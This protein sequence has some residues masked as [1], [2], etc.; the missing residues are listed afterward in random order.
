MPTLLPFNFH[1]YDG[2]APAPTALAVN[3]T[4]VPEQISVDEAPMVTDGDTWLPTDIVMEFDATVNG[5]AQPSDDV[6]ANV[7]T[8]LFDSDEFR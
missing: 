5:F 6:I 8:S 3:V 7:T 4:G 2:V 1:W